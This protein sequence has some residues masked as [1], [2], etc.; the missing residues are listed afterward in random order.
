MNAIRRTGTERACASCGR[1]NLVL[2]PEGCC[3]SEFVWYARCGRCGEWRW[4]HSREDASFVL[5]VRETARRRG[6]P[7]GLSPGGT[8]EAHA[9]YEATL[10]PCPCGGRFHVVRDVL[11]EA[12]IGC[13]RAL[14][15]ARI[16]AGPGR[17]IEVGPVRFQRD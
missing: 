6:E 4:F 13:G 1:A 8:L 7:G 5:A 17:G 14:R 9:A 2:L 11:D 16:G 3:G 12:C 10:D 15:E